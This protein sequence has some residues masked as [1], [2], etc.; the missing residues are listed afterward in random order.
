MYS[1]G[2][3]LS[4]SVEKS[5]CKQNWKRRYK[6]NQGTRAK[7]SAIK[8]AA[9]GESGWFKVL[10]Q[11]VPKVFQE[12]SCRRPSCCLIPDSNAYTSLI[13]FC[14]LLT[15]GLRLFLSFSSF[16]WHV[17]SANRCHS[18]GQESAL[19]LNYNIKD[20]LWKPL[21]APTLSY[22][23][24]VWSLKSSRVANRNSKFQQLAKDKK[25][26]SNQWEVHLLEFKFMWRHL[27]W[28]SV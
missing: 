3:H 14:F 15:L 17:M 27:V 2:G 13:A 23:Y 16:V 20:L 6:I 18:N 24:L 28:S 22:F 7:H 25:L 10:K 12:L 26:N 4:R 8:E 19:K 21:L 5:W 11:G 9:P 1:S